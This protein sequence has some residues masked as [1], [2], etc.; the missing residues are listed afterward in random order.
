MEFKKLMT[1]VALFGAMSFGASTASANTGA[2]ADFDAHYTVA[3]GCTDCHTGTPGAI[4]PL[5][6]AWKAAGGSKNAGPTGAAGWAALDAV[7]EA[8]Y[9]PVKTTPTTT[10][11]AATTDSG[12]GGGCVTSVATPLTIV[13]AMLTLGFFVRRKKD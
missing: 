2:A 8:T 7:Y 13:L 1:V 6:S 5:G 12:G 3:S 9:G 4:T 10:T 11:P